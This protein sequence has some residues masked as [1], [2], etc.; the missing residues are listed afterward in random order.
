MKLVKI[1]VACLLVSS[2]ACESKKIEKPLEKKVEKIEKKVEK[3]VE[4]KVQAESKPVEKED[5]L[6]QWVAM[7]NYGVRFRVPAEWKVQ[8]SDVSATANSADGSITV[9]LIG[10]DSE[11]MIQNALEKFK[12][13]VNFEEIKTKSSGATSING[14]PGY[15][16]TGSA[17][18]VVGDT[19]N[20]IQYLMNAV[21]VGGKAAALLIFADATM[22]EAKKEEI[23]GLAKTLKKR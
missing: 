20:E 22:Y 12:K 17:V 18:H 8:K 13:E 19:K 23:D 10:T 3:V 15:S 4:K 21:K 6:G 1:L 9:I 2:V 11:N 7:D 16:A 5:T 14:M